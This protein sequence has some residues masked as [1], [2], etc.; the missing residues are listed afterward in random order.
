MKTRDPGRF[1]RWPALLIFAVILLAAVVVVRFAGGW[2]EAATT[3]AGHNHAATPAATS[4]MPVML[5]S[6]QVQRIGV[7]YAPVRMGPLGRV[8]RTVATVSYDETRLKSVTARVDGWVERLYL[9]FTGQAVRIG[10]PLFS[11]YSPML[12]SAQQE[13][14]LAKRLR[15]NVAAGSPDAIRGADE[16]L[17]SARRRLL[18]WEVP[19][20][21]VA[22][23][24]KALTF[25]SP[26]RGVVIEKSVLGGQRIMAGETLFRIADLSTVWLE[27]EVFERDLPA[28]RLGLQVVAEFPALPGA[29]RTGR[30]TYIYPTLNPE[31]RTARVRVELANPR[32]ELKPGMYATFS[33]AAAT[34]P[35]LSVPRSAILSTGKRDLVFVRLQ[36]GSLVARDVTLGL[37]TDERIEIL[38][39]LALGETVVASATF[40]VDAESNLATLLG[41]MGNMPGMDISAPPVPAGTRAPEAPAAKLPPKDTMKMKMPEDEHAGHSVPGRD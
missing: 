29:P 22:Q 33:F 15:E 27:G 10:E 5:T 8:V 31:T 39:G 13:L 7:T 28:V 34:E 30:I 4:A 20:T 21:D 6:E 32:L 3:P 26:V 23:I 41:G 25:R 40:L 37:A 1:G 35:V 36:D 11:L 2:G 14:L 9:D 19:A 12:V 24:R 17:E 38:S 16:L 18:Y